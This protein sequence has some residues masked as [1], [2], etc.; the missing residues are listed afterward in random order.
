MPGMIK[1]V[2]DNEFVRNIKTDVIGM[3]VYCMLF[4]E[5]DA[6]PDHIR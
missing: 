1:S 3:Q 5:Q 6:D 2:A 4:P